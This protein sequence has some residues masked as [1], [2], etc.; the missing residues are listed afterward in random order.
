M[1]LA[2]YRENI[3]RLNSAFPNQGAISI[4]ECAKFLSLD[5]KTVYNLIKPYN[6]NPIP[7]KLIGTR[8]RVIPVV[9]L[10]RWLC[11]R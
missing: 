8:R 7:T 2:G 9:A 5:V 11:Q 10:A 3:E 1:E 4:P 6:K